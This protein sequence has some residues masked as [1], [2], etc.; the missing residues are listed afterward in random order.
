M[1]GILQNR[2]A[3]VSEA[4]CAALLFGVSAPLAKQLLGEVSPQL[5]AG[6][7]Y[8]GSGVGLGA[9]WLWRRSPLAPV[10]A[11][12]RI[13]DVPAVAAAIGF[14]GVLAPLLLLAGLQQTPA[15]TASLLLNLETVFTASLAWI[16][17]KETVGPRI[18][19]GMMSIVCGG[20]ILSSTEA[21]RLTGWVGPLCIAGACL[22]WGIDNNITQK[23]STHDPVQIAAIKGLVAGMVNAILA[24]VLGSPR[25]DWSFIGAALLLGF[26]SYGVSLVLYIR[27]LRKLGTARTGNYFSLAP[28]IGTVISVALWREPVTLPLLAAGLLMGIGLWLHLTERH[29][30]M[31][32]HE[33]LDHEH[34]HVHDEHH[35]H[36]HKPGDPQGEPHSHPHHHDRLEHSHEHYPDIHHRHDH[37]PKT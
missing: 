36:E 24:A 32:V 14:G 34:A 2:H 31:H 6:L 21:A 35:Q 22:C 20:I 3:G 37:N 12:L 18:A 30:H 17:F 29:R 26:V 19:L 4:L 27:A 8:L 1:N 25:P 11:S 9:L 23:V 15:S 5:L 13:S 16:A 28:F 10:E 33:P 7:L